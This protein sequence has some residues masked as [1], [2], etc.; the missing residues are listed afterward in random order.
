MELA[1]SFVLKIRNSRSLFGVD[2]ARFFKLVRQ[3]QERRSEMQ[4][5][6]GVFDELILNVSCNLRTLGVNLLYQVE[7]KSSDISIGT[8]SL[9]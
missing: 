8:D 9:F 6:Q 3:L 4:K 2:L 1:E 7:E 5:D